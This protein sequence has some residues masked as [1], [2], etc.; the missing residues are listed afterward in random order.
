VVGGFLTLPHIL[1]GEGLPSLLKK[2]STGGLDVQQLWERMK[3]S[4]SLQGRDVREHATSSALMSG[5]FGDYTVSGLER[6]MQEWNRN[7]E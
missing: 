1:F 5:L 2:I 4:V 6:Q 7:P 3:N